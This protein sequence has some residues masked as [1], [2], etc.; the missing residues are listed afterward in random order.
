[1]GMNNQIKAIR[2][3]LGLTQQDLA[4][5]AG[6]ARQT[7]GGIE[8]GA[9]AVSVHVALRIARA[10][11]CQVDEL[12]WLD[13]ETPTVLAR[14]TVPVVVEPYPKHVS[15]AQVDGKWIAH[16]LDQD[17][18][19]ASEMRTV[20]GLVTWSNEN[21][22]VTVKLQD[23][24][25]SLA[26]TVAI[27]GC[28][29]TLPLWA[30]AAE[31]WNPGLR[32]LCLHANSTSALL[33]LTR[34]EVHAAGLHLSDYASGEGNLPFVKSALGTRQAVLVNL[35]VWEEGFVVEKGNPKSVK[36]APDLLRT[37]I[38]VINRDIGSGA[39]QLLD[40]LISDS[41]GSHE[42]VVGYDNIVRSHREI[43]R[44]VRHGQSDVGIAIVSVAT[45][46]DL[47][48][49]PL[50]QVQYDIALLKEY[51]DHQAVQQMVSALNHRWVKTQ[52]RATGGFDT[53]LTGDIVGTT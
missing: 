14:S 11:G 36:G 27:A 29:P 6:V 31:R 3:R 1:M 16:P 45:A 38:T 5:A 35:G 32:T 50:R 30:R 33:S 19:F 23:D 52:L 42:H 49:V 40:R 37:D 12:F 15:L 8:S 25:K 17:A 10:L 21:N 34:G 53:R 24:P 39:R 28:A 20:D 22:E 9:Y 44:A 13:E 43:A 51:L 18:A 4:V 2:T 41:G 48:F 47:D 46:Y 26:S 7:V